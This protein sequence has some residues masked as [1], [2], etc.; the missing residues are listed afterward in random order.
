VSSDS[1]LLILVFFSR[2]CRFPD[3]RRSVY[4][5]GRLGATLHFLI[6]ILPTPQFPLLLSFPLSFDCGVQLDLTLSF[7]V[8]KHLRVHLRLELLR[9]RT[10]IISYT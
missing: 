6:P 9:Y 4:T 1:T 3:R 7:P 5:Y 10:F 2:R 8:Q